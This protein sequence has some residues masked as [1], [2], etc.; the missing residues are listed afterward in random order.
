MEV[1]LSVHPH[2][3]L[4]GLGAPSKAKSITVENILSPSTAAKTAL[5]SSHPPPRVTRAA[6]KKG[7][8]F[9]FSFSFRFFCLFPLHSY[10]LV[11]DLHKRNLL[12]EL[13]L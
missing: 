9:Q 4:I 10:L 6:S 11:Q 12:K 8:Y 5:V 1:C 3:L 2:D 13:K 7:K